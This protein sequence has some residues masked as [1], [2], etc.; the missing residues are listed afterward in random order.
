MIQDLTSGNQHYE[1]KEWMLICHNNT[2]YPNIADC[3]EDYNWSSSST[4]YAN[5]EELPTFITRHR[6]LGQ[7]CQF[8]TTANHIHLK[9]TIGCLQFSEKS[10]RKR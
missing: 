2:N 1:A 8:T 4:A 3:D 5:L 7:E 10:Y 9:E 6:Q